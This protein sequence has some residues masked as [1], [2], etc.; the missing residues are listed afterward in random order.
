MPDAFFLGA[1]VCKQFRDEWFL[2]TVVSTRVDEGDHLWNVVYSNCDSEDVTKEQLAKML[3]WHP[4]LTDAEEVVIPEVGTFVWF[5]ADQLPCLG[6]VVATDASSA[7]PITVRVY[8][9]QGRHSDLP[10]DCFK[11][12]VDPED[13]EAPVVRQI[14]VHEVMLRFPELSVRGFMSAKVRRRF[15]KALSV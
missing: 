15:A 7:R 12:A 8:E 11:P 14:A 6:K 9:P 1:K 10:K 5:A 4:A 2:G 13:E 3:V